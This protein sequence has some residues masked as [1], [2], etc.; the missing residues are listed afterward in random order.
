MRKELVSVGNVA[1]GENLK[2]LLA[3]A[4]G[5]VQREQNGPYDEAATEADVAEHLEKTKE[6][7]AVDGAM[8]QDEGVRGLEEWP[9]P[10]DESGRELWARVSG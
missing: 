4:S 7:E 3:F 6:E 9:D 2:L 1:H 8:V 5:G 10:V